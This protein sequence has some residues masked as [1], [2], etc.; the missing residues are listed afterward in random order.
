MTKQEIENRILSITDDFLSHKY[1]SI[2][3]KSIG[4]AAENS[5]YYKKSEN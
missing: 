1:V 3:D 4:F 5:T 2:K